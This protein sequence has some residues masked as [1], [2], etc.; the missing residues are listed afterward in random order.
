MACA[1]T[2]IWSLNARMARAAA[3]GHLSPTL[4]PTLTELILTTLSD[5]ALRAQFGA[6][7]EALVLGID[8]VIEPLKAEI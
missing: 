4:V 6:R 7:Y 1:E 8:A 3:N 5:M 2:L